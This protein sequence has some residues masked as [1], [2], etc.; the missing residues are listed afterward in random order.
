MLARADLCFARPT[1]IQGRPAAVAAPR[2]RRIESPMTTARRVCR[3]RSSRTKG[4][5]DGWE[6]SGTRT[7]PYQN[8]IMF[9]GF[10]F[11]LITAY[12][13]CLSAV[14]KARF[15]RYSSGSGIAAEMSRVKPLL[16]S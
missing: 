4:L 2:S 12:A 15:G 6:S 10:G 3:S 8:L 1:R 5:G 11:L 16:S 9:R 7:A 14:H 13:Y